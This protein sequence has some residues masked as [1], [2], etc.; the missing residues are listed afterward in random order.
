[1][2]GKGATCTTFLRT[3]SFK[4]QTV[5]ITLNFMFLY[6]GSNDNET[7]EGGKLG[8]IYILLL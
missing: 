3:Q 4:R 5:S 6:V 1:M 7:Q 2:R 8:Y